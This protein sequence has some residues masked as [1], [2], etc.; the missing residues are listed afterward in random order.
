M[1]ILN[2][3]VLSSVVSNIKS[4]FVSK[5]ELNNHTSTHAP[6]NAEKNIIVGIQKM[7]QI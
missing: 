1:E 3:D 5:T 2:L 6:S 7:E 4:L